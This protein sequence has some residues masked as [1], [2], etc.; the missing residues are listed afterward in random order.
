MS[1]KA[2]E[3][4]AKSNLDSLKIACDYYSTA[5]HTLK[6]RVQFYFEEF[7]ASNAMISFLTNCRDQIEK[8]IYTMEPR[9]EQ[10]AAKPYVIDVPQAEAS[11]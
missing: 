1:D 10:E 7:E 9:K 4:K 5:L 11:L 2:S 6:T 8:E 3:T